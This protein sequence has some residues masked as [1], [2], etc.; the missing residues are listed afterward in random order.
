MNVNYF[1]KSIF[2]NAIAKI[3]EKYYSRIMKNWTLNNEKQTY[4]IIDSTI[5]Q[6]TINLFDKMMIIIKSISMKFQKAMN[7]LKNKIQKKLER[8]ILKQKKFQRT[9]KKVAKIRNLNVKLKAFLIV[10]TINKIVL[11][12]IK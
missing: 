9:T 5:I 11:T 1:K 3:F 6:K 12:Q 8:R 2:R 7:M 4:E 10:F